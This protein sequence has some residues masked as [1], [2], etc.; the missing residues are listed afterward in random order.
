MPIKAK[1]KPG[2]PKG[3][4]VERVEL[5][6]KTKLSKKL[7]ESAMRNNWPSLGAYIVAILDGRVRW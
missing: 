1:R 4:A 5:R 7:K 2:R 6:L 3:D